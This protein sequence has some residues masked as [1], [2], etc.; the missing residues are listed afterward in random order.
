MLAASNI[1]FEAAK[2]SSRVAFTTKEAIN[3]TFRIECI[4]MGEEARSEESSF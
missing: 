3:F 1:Q 2:L 4:S